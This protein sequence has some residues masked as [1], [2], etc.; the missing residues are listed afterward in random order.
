MNLPIIL[1]IIGILGFVLNR[2]NIIL[3]LISIEIMLLS[4]TLI[5]IISSYALDDIVGQTFGIYVI[6]V[7]GAESAIG[8]SILIGYYRLSYFLIFNYVCLD[9]YKP[10]IRVYTEKIQSFISYYTSVIDCENNVISSEKKDHFTFTGVHMP[11]CGG[12]DNLSQ[13]SCNIDPWFVTGLFDAESSF[14]ITILKNADL[15]TGWRVQA[16]VQL[17]MH[18]RDR[19]LVQSISNYFKGIGYVTKPNNL[20]TVEFRVSTLKDIVDVIIPHFDNYPLITKKRSDYELFKKI[21]LLMLNKEHNTLE[22]LH[23]IVNIRASINLGLPNSLKKA[24]PDTEAVKRIENFIDDST[25]L[26]RGWVAGF[27]T[28]ESNF[29]IAVQK[30]KTKC[31]FTTSLRFSIGQHSRD[32]LLMEKFVNFFGCGYV[33]NYEKRSV[34]EFIITKID[35]IVNYVI[36]F[37][38]KHPIQGSKHLAYIDFKKASLIIKNKEHLNEEGLEQILQ[39]KKK[40]TELYVNKTVNEDSDE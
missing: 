19:V 35:D 30:S 29:F 7:A 27:T 25:V 23:K 26:N 3:M 13:L 24:F 1:F 15:K 2:K 6:S 28:G 38:E 14:V 8:L 10:F 11:R 4:I 37:Y 9:T 22:G 32:I 34:C 39:L 12:V 31:G 18:E 16:R 36:P 40:I 21:I 33:V 5:I 17:K 20:S